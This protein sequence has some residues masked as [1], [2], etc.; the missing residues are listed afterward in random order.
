M[1]GEQY[2]CIVL[3][4]LG[5]RSHMSHFSIQESV[6]HLDKYQASLGLM[7]GFSHRV[8]HYKA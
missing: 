3:D 6:E 1:T 5:N 8:V 2:K 7:T 4:A